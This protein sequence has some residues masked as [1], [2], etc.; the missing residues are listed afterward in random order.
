M[1]TLESLQGIMEGHGQR[2]PRQGVWKVDLLNNL[3]PL[4]LGCDIVGLYEL[5]VPKNEDHSTLPCQWP[6]S[7]AN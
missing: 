5:D 4:L 7:R 1:E 6:F 2:K 3:V